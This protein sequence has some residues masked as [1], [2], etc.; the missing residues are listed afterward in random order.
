MPDLK[1]Q[2]AS[3]VWEAV[4][5][6]FNETLTT[7]LQIYLGIRSVATNRIKVTKG[8]GGP[9]SIATQAFGAA[10]DPFDFLLFMAMISVN[11]AVLNFLPIPVLD[12]GHMVLLIYEKIRGKP[13][14][15]AWRN[16]LTI[17]GLSILVLLM[18]GATFLDISKL[19]K[20]LK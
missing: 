16:T 9:I 20:I 13:P 1:R 3:S 2:Q 12:G 7:T 10:E 17:A 15:D 18:L 11:L 4:E 8:L 14:S 19:L 5:L 6:G